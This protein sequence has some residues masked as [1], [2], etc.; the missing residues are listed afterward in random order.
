MR[1]SQSIATCTREDHNAL[2]ESSEAEW[3]TL[4]HRRD[5]V[6]EDETLEQRDCP[7]C[8]STLARPKRT[9]AA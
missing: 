7:K 3:N 9:E 8:G 5:W 6:L 4:V 2:R 1:P